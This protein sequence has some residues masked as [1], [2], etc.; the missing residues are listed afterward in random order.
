MGSCLSCR[1]GNNVVVIEGA[2]TKTL[3]SSSQP[4]STGGKDDQFVASSN[5]PE[6]TDTHS[7]N[8]SYFSPYL[9]YEHFRSPLST[10]IVEEEDQ[11]MQP[12][13]EEEEGKDPILDTPIKAN[14][15]KIPPGMP[16]HC[17]FVQSQKLMTK[18]EDNPNQDAVSQDCVAVFQSLRLIKLM[19]K[20]STEKKRKQRKVDT[21][22]KDIETNHQLWQSFQGIQS[23][24]SSMNSHIVFSGCSGLMDT[25]HFDFNSAEFEDNSSQCSE[26]LSL[27]SQ[28]GLEMQRQYFEEKRQR[29]V[30]TKSMSISK[31]S[32]GGGGSGSVSSCGSKDYGPLRQTV[33]LKD[34]EV[35]VP[36]N[37]S[38]E[39]NFG[40]EVASYVSDLGDESTIG[41]NTSSL[42]RYDYAVPHRRKR[43]VMPCSSKSLRAKLD[44][45]EDAVSGLRES[46]QNQARNEESAPLN[47][48][49]DQG[50]TDHSG[51]VHNGEP[52]SFES[53]TFHST[54]TDLLQVVQEIS[55][56]TGDESSVN[57]EFG[58]LRK[59]E[60]TRISFPASRE[61]A[62]VGLGSVN[63]EHKN[64]H[65][66]KEL[67]ENS[68][69]RPVSPLTVS[70][71]NLMRN[72]SS[73]IQD[74]TRSSGDSEWTYQAE[75]QA[76][77]VL[78]KSRSDVYSL[79]TE[80]FRRMSF[81]DPFSFFG[82]RQ[83][84]YPDT[85]FDEDSIE[86]PEEEELECPELRDDIWNSNSYS[87]DHTEMNQILRTSSFEKP[88][89]DSV[90]LHLHLIDE[91]EN[92]MTA[93][94]T[95]LK[96]SN[97]E[98]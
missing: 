88:S 15:S 74:E 94:L 56:A 85:P 32:A 78:Q 2:L 81:G 55:Y 9:T 22:I 27:L 11:S 25:M 31:P 79:S 13:D 43:S 76:K 10:V 18:P 47:F 5:S 69:S 52:I 35:F 87:L 7:S 97:E 36:Q 64:V 67:P 61:P 14:I 33:V 59:K 68:Y 41:S 21:Q 46:Q 62:L 39:S 29:K 24:V 60:S 57:S 82:P 1:Q 93:V 44:L 77:R 66:A 28:E 91:V 71:K 92:Q 45:L 58:E 51:L 63:A 65:P 53:P 90:P 73:G 98:Y 3:E 30:S 34:M 75:S 6:T 20:K 83:D 17:R 95:K 40:C 37:E 72:R 12:S 96:Q 80:E 23:E 48:D 38:T 8:S 54:P 86:V 42:C 49:E 16:V 26:N 70:T 89:N 4:K 19:K 50:A 84:V